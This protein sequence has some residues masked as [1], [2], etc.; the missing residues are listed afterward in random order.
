MEVYGTSRKIIVVQV[1]GTS[2]KSVPEM[3]GSTPNLVDDSSNQ[4]HF[5]SY[6]EGFS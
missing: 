2:R 6:F 1:Y 3:G 4:V 5:L